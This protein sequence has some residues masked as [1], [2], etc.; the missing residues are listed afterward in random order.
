MCGTF[1]R[2]RIPRVG[3]SLGRLRGDFSTRVSFVPCHNSFPHNVFT[4]LMIG[5]GMTL[6]RVMHVCRRCCTGSSFIRVISGGV[7]LGRMMGAGG[8]LVRLRGRNSGL[9]VVSY[10]SGLLGNTS[11]RTIRGVGLV[12]GLRRAM[13]LHLGPSTFWRRAVGLF[14]MCPLF[15]VG[16]VGKGNYRI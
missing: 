11:K 8:Y 1:R 3:R 14:S 16:V 4:A 15:S 12:F 7:S 13:N 10:V 9:L 6:R 2:R 5:A